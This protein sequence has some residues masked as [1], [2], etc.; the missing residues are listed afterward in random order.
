MR[1]AT[2]QGTLSWVGMSDGCDPW[3]T[4][5]PQDF[6]WAEHSGVYDQWDTNDPEDVKE[7]A[8]SG[9]FPFTQTCQDRTAVFCILF[10]S[11][12]LIFAGIALC[13]IGIFPYFVGGILILSGL[14]MLVTGLCGIVLLRKAC[15]EEKRIQQELQR[16]DAEI[17]ATEKHLGAKKKAKRKTTGPNHR[18]YLGLLRGRRKCLDWCLQNTKKGYWKLSGVCLDTRMQSLGGASHLIS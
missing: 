1:V 3:D 9:C 10:A 16:L 2:T 17:L 15:T 18:V 13:V 8:K 5:D 12:V 4:C 14:S 6:S 7:V 11:V